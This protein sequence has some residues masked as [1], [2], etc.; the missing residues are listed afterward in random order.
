MSRIPGRNS[1]DMTIKHHKR[2]SKRRHRIENMSAHLNDWRSVAIRHD[3]FT[4]VFL[5]ALAPAASVIT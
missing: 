4:K 2:C 3:R 5:S 1:N